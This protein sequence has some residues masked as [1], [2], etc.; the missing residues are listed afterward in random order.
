MR[1]KD[2]RYFDEKPAPN[3]MFKGIWGFCRRRAPHPQVGVFQEM[4]TTLWP[5]VSANEW[6]GEYEPG[7]TYKGKPISFA[8]MPYAVYRPSQA[9][10]SV[11]ECL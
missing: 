7:F 3:I 5:D 1:C 4:I 10:R 11:V 9:A 8:D 2:C 6:C